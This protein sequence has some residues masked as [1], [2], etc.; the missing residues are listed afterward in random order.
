MD[1][2]II[3]AGRRLGGHQY[4]PLIHRWLP[5]GYAPIVLSLM[6]LRVAEVIYRGG[7]CVPHL[8]RRCYTCQTPHYF[9]TGHAVRCRGSVFAAVRSLQLRP[10]DDFLVRVFTDRVDSL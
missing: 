2:S 10:E 9:G 5:G 3:R 8:V 7:Y 6:G 4:L 1:A